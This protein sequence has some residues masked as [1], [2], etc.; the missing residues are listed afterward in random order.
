MENQEDCVVVNSTDFKTRLT[1]NSFSP[2]TLSFL[3]QFP[4]CNMVIV[5]GPTLLHSG[6]K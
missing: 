2:V 6:E 3:P 5:I 4:H 1:V